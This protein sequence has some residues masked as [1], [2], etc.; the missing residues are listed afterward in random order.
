MHRTA[1]IAPDI[2]LPAQQNVDRDHLVRRTGS[3]AVRA[4]QVDQPYRRFA[5]AHAAD[6]LLDGHA[7]DNSPRGPAFPPAQ[8]NN[9]LL[10]VFG[11]PTKATVIVRGSAAAVVGR[12]MLYIVCE[13]VFAP[14]GRQRANGRT[15]GRKNWFDERSGHPVGGGFAPGASRSQ[16]FDVKAARFAGPER[17]A[18]SSHLKLDG[19]SHRGE[20]DDF[21]LLPFGEPHL[22]QADGHAVLAPRH[23]NGRAFAGP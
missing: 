17:D 18:V 23:H 10:P 4:G 6:F 11:F 21:D 8:L 5:A 2:G 7:R 22:Q 20:S 15:I 19:V 14:P 12:T 9:V 16:S 1:S 3:Q 13:S